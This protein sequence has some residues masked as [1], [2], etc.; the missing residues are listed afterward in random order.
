MNVGFKEKMVYVQLSFDDGGAQG[1]IIPANE[2][3]DRAYTLPLY[4]SL[5]G[6][7]EPT[8]AS[9]SFN[10]EMH[11]DS[12]YRYDW[13]VGIGEPNPWWD[14]HGRMLPIRSI[15]VQLS[16]DCADSGFG[17]SD[18]PPMLLGLQPSLH[19]PTWLERYGATLRE[20]VRGG[21]DI[22][23][24]YIPIL[25]GAVKLGSNFI[26]SGEHDQ[27][28]WWIYRFLDVERKCCVIEWNINHRVLEE[29]GPLLRG[30]V[31]LAFHGARRNGG[32]L[33][34]LLHPR[35]GFD[36]RRGEEIQYL[37]PAEQ[38]D[39]DETR[40]SLALRPQFAPVT[41]PAKRSG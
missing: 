12:S 14:W 24:P 31:V 2:A 35:L 34:L 4:Y 27:K 23:Q 9:L 29:Y 10:Y 7:L 19:T 3:R 33:N 41:S 32:G 40:V 21:A 16:I 26:P 30:S 28:N 36:K 37:P 17:F 6:E 39:T 8:L 13:L 11:A 15:A 5:M 38:L 18:S 20:T 1:R 22:A 25:P